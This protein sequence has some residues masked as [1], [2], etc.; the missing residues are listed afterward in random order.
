LE[1]RPIKPAWLS[2]YLR[3]K[4]HQKKNHLIKW[5][6]WEEYRQWAFQ[7][8][9]FEPNEVNSCTQFLVE[10]GMLMTLVHEV[11][12]AVPNLVILDPKWLAEVFSTVVSI[13]LGS[14]H[15]RYLGFMKR[16]TL[17][18]RWREKN[19]AEEMFDR[20]ESLLRM[21][22]LMIPMNQKVIGDPTLEFDLFI[23]SMAWRPLEI[24]KPIIEDLEMNWPKICPSFVEFGRRLE[25]SFIPTGYL[26]QVLARICEIKGVKIIHRIIQRHDYILKYEQDDNY[27]KKSRGEPRI[28]LFENGNCVTILFRCDKTCV[29]SML[30]HLLFSTLEE[31]VKDF[32]VI[33]NVN[34]I[35]VLYNGEDWGSVGKFEAMLVE[36]RSG[37][38]L[39]RLA[40][41]LLFINVPQ[42]FSND[43][44]IGEKLAEGRNGVVYKGVTISD[45]AVVVI[46]EPKINQKNQGLKEFRREVLVMHML[47]KKEEPCV[48][49]LLGVYINFERKCIGLVLEF[50]QRPDLSHF[51]EYEENPIRQ[52]NV[53]QTR[54]KDSELWNSLQRPSFK[55]RVAQDVAQGM[56]HM[57][58][59]SF[60]SPLI[61]TDLR[62][63]NIFLNGHD[64]TSKN[65]VAVVG[66]V[67]GAV[68]ASRVYKVIDSNEL[69]PEMRFTATWT[70]FGQAADVY[71][72]GVILWEL[73]SLKFPPTLGRTFL[74][75]GGFFDIN[76][77]LWNS[78][79]EKIL[80]GVMMKCCNVNP[81]E[82]PTFVDILKMLW[83]W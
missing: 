33:P 29:D 36:G 61:H 77:K 38:A 41:D 76:Y 74:F 78:S 54:L 7:V 1:R 11:S 10:C 47:G 73:L 58:C 2:L 68:L 23:P 75:E 28:R 19:Y 66:D 63:S 5:I 82:R 12:I 53:N 43:I 60:S 80:I 30:L 67:G 70:G 79:E 65:A 4:E 27:F 25:L 50:I 64:E 8:G 18:K 69:A 17:H 81:S 59:M 15:Y 20:I 46:K 45:Q 49:R 62:C 31:R 14:S 57:H 24:A 39:E 44:Q 83:N 51:L 22:K 16:E 26:Q 71:C 40:P 6:E 32:V 3:I 21:F 55:L 9:I 48:N 37:E 56:A 52:L 42:Y 72:F 34:K 35:E 13:S